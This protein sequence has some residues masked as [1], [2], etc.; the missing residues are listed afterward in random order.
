MVLKEGTIVPSLSGIDLDGN[1]YALAY[2]SDPRKV[3]MFVFSPRCGFCTKNM[4]NWIAIADTLDRKSFRIVAVSI[5][6]EGVKDYVSQSK[7]AGVPI[8]AEVDPK[9]RLSYEM[10]VTPQTIL[11]DSTGRV[12]KVWIGLTLKDDRA[13]IERSLKVKLPTS[14]DD[15][16]LITNA[17]EG[18]RA[19]SRS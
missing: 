4:P 5:V 9:S 2:G 6:S 12:E 13:D 18:R 7:L 11:I 17:T 8:I 10:T 14:A 19:R 16:S 15:V 1:R 3:V